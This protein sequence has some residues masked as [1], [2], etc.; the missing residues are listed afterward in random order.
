MV[1]GAKEC[2]TSISL[3]DVLG[4]SGKKGRDVAHATDSLHPDTGLVR[5]RGLP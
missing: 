1:V 5:L 2:L 4:S 3:P